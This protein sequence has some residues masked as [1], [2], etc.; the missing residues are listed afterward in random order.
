MVN[1]GQA[2][3]VAAKAGMGIAMLPE[4]LAQRDILDGGLE[5]LLPAWRLP[6]QPMSLLYHRDRY[7]PQRLSRFIDFARDTFG[8]SL[9]DER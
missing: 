3:R 1:S 4:V 8:K 5:Q 6:E 9:L 2:L 7:M